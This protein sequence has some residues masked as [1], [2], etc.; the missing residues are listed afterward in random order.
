MNRK[1]PNLQLRLSK[2]RLLLF[3]SAAFLAGVAF[4]DAKDIAAPW[5]DY[6]RARR[7]ACNADIERVRK[8]DVSVVLTNREGK[9]LVDRPCRIRQLSSDFTWGCNGLL[10]GQIGETNAA[11]EAKLSEFFNLVTTTFCPGVMEP[12]KG[13]YRFAADSEE[14]WRRPPSDRVL[15]FTRAHG[16][17]MKGQPLVCDR[18]HPKWAMGQTKE[19]AEAHYREWFRRVAER[20]GKSVWY[21]DVVNEAFDARRRT[22]DFPLYQRDETL[23]FVDWSFAEAGKVFPREC[24]L[25]I[26]MGGAATDWRKSGRRYYELCARI[27]SKG[28]RLDAIGF[29]FHLFNK[30]AARDFVQ[31][32][33]WHPNMLRHSYET[34]SRLGR[35]LFITEIT[36]PSTI[37]PGESGRALQAEVAGDLYR[38]WFS[39]PEIHGVTW[40]NLCDGAA[41]GHED[42]VKGALLDEKMEDKPVFKT[43]RHLITQEWRTSLSTRTD[44]AGRVVFRGF[45]G[46]YEADFGNGEV[47]R[48]EVR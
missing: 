27:I 45:R 26:N 11:Y 3:A 19:E 34:F 2:S 41:W 22:P 48:F 38:F 9:V 5:R 12:E 23:S 29:Q 40:W 20:Y 35:P 18:W 31:L 16:M 7:A 4:A 24:V 21:F 46:T 44:S 15:A 8:A 33:K 14:V 39:R 47:V 42:D 37:L 30:R 1:R 28:I 32:K 6:W 13:H 17:R 25:G 36:I 43:L 10:L